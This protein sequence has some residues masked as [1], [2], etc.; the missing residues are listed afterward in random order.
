MFLG[1]HA[2]VGATCQKYLKN[3]LLW[4][5]LALASHGIL[6]ASAV[7][8]NH[9]QS[10]IL[11]VVLGLSSLVAYVVIFR[12]HRYGIGAIVAD[13]PALEWGVKSAMGIPHEPLTQ[14]SPHYWIQK[15]PEWNWHGQ[16]GHEW[17]VAVELGLVALC[18]YWLVMHERYN[19]WRRLRERASVRLEHAKAPSPMALSPEESQSPA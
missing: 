3:P 17:G 8:H 10:F 4:V 9:E 18:I 7:F 11:A 16:Y 19:P 5:P 14:Y 15:W 12:D 1:T 6:D 13:L 2:I